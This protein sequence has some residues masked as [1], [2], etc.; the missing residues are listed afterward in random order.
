LRELNIYKD[1]SFEVL[2]ITSKVNTDYLFEKYRPYFFAHLASQSSVTKGT[3][4]KALTKDN[5]IISENLIN[6]LIYYSKKTKMFF[7]SSATIYEGYKNKKVDEKTPPKPLTIYSKTKYNTHKKL[8]RLI[9]EKDV[10]GNIGIMFSHESE[11]RRP[12][13]FSKTIVEFLIAYL[14][15][16]RR[17]LTVG[18]IL[19]QRDIGYAE[20]Y[21]NA[22]YKIMNSS[23]NDEFII[24]S[25]KLVTLKDFIK[26]CLNLLNIN[27]EII[28]EQKKLSFID[29][30]TGKA[31]IVSEPSLF[32]E[33]DLHGIRGDNSKII[34]EIGWTPTYDLEQICLKM[35]SYELR[36]LN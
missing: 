5:E 27:Y 4:H 29:K 17:I 11:F 14:E 33:V 24:S 28:E 22:I 6:S 18:N 2:D 16:K 21:V 7:P 10:L 32:R 20:E 23:K 1:I 30:A 9:D 8:K 19:I 26:T 31:F 3:T 25:N 36:K 34:N 12:N 35:L 13:F 15:K